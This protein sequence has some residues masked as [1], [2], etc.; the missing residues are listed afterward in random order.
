MSKQEKNN[1]FT[2]IGGLVHSWKLFFNKTHIPEKHTAEY[3][4]A[5]RINLKT[6]EM[7]ILKTDDS[8]FLM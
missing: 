6:T 1:F 5:R 4:I 7:L 8:F 2:K 3:D